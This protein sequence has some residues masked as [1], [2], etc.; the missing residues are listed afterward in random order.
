LIAAIVAITGF[1]CKEKGKKDIDQGEIHYAIEYSGDV[2][3]FREIMPRNLIVSFKD[4]NILFDI[5]APIG[6]SGILNLSNPEK[7]IFDT[8]IS[9]FTWRYY[10]SAMEGEDPPGFN[11]MKGMSVKK[12]LRTKDI[13]GFNCKNAEVTLS[14]GRTFEVWYTT[15]IEIESPNRSNPYSEIDGILMS[16]YFFMGDARMFFNAEAVYRKEIPD[17]TFERRDKYQRISREEID[18]F[19]DKLI[20]L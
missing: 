14:D 5:S 12:T 18:K 1:T 7:G 16:F 19:I 13:C 15:E 17:R 2:G 10:Y 9:L 8:Y 6:N 11:A 4:N 20:S 3:S